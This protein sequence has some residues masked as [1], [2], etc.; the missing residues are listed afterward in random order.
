MM[1]KDLW[2]LVGQAGNINEFNVTAALDKLINHLCFSVSLT[3]KDNLTS[4]L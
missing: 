4:R 3:A 1:S 2:L